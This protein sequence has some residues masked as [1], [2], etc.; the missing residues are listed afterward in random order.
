MLVKRTHGS[1]CPTSALVLLALAVVLA[2]EHD[3]LYE[4]SRAAV[5]EVQTI[6]DFRGLAPEGQ[7]QPTAGWEPTQDQLRHA[8]IIGEPSKM[9]VKRTHAA[10]WP[11]GAH[12]LMVVALVV[13]LVL[14]QGCLY[15]KSQ[16]RIT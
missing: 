8:L 12:V 3:C 13:V 1:T 16:R 6:L 14:E 9:L 4:K 7:V 11:T 5:C 2:L 15:E 10:M